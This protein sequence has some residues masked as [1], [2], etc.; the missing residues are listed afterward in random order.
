MWRR[1]RSGQVCICCFST[2]HSCILTLCNYCLV[3]STLSMAHW[4][5]LTKDHHCSVQRGGSAQSHGHVHQ[6]LWGWKDGSWRT[7]TCVCVCVCVC[8]C[9][10]AHSVVSDSLWPYGQ[11]RILKW[12]AISSYRGSSWL[13]GLNQCL[14]GGLF[15]SEPPGKPHRNGNP[16]QYSCLENPMDRGAW[17]VIVHRVAKSWIQL[18]NKHFTFLTGTEPPI[19]VRKK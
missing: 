14:A 4:K 19:Q 2:W 13:R 17:R 5:N 6:D 18:S 16:L 9:A 8:V 7:N 15:T 10:R 12:V 11:E 1:G 3:L